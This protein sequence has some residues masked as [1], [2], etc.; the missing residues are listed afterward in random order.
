MCV[1]VGGRGG[2]GTCKINMMGGQGGS[3]IKQIREVI[4]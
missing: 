3:E 2:G 1:C 4:K